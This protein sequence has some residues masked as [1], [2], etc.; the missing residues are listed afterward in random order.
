M[1]EI[2]ILQIWQHL[3]WKSW[4]RAFSMSSGRRPSHSRW[5]N[6]QKPWCRGRRSE[7]WKQPKK[8]MLSVSATC[9]I[10]SSDLCSNVSSLEIFHRLSAEMVLPGTGSICV[11]ILSRNVGWQLH[12]LRLRSRKKRESVIKINRLFKRLWASINSLS[13]NFQIMNHHTVTAKNH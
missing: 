5:K 3:W 7:A 8:T 4:S 13:L 10:W 1:Q 12:K 11:E 9:I 2:Q 6:C